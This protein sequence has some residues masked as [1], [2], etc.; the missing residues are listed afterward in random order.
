MMVLDIKAKRKL[1][2]MNRTETLLHFATGSYDMK[3]REEMSP[4]YM[5]KCFLYYAHPKDLLLALL[6]NVLSNVEK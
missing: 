2:E 5:S 4:K 1:L 3:L 6:R